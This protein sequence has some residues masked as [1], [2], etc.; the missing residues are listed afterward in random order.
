MIWSFLLLAV[1]DP[2]PAAPDRP[3]GEPI[4]DWLISAGPVGILALVA[5]AF[6]T[7]RI[8]PASTLNDVR[9]ER[10]RALDLVYKQADIAGRAL[11]VSE[12]VTKT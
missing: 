3:T 4:L 10:D 7:G 8:V 9:V 1:A 2:T 11:E 12:K 6:L 5:W